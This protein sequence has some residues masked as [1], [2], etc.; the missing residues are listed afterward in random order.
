MKRKQPS[1]YGEV[2]APLRRLHRE[3]ETLV[4]RLGK[5]VILCGGILYTRLSLYREL[6]KTDP[7]MA[8][9]FAFEPDALTP[10]QIAEVE[11]YWQPCPR[12]VWDHR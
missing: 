12:E 11:A 4:K 1:K 8:D 10:E 9:Y 7:R 5:E 6:E 3:R 2:P